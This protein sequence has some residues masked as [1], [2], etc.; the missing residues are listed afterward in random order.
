MGTVGF[1]TTCLAQELSWVR[2]LLAI[3]FTSG[4]IV[5]VLAAAGWL[6]VSTQVRL[7]WLR[8]KAWK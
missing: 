4:A 6:S 2:P 5:G 7:W 8:R 1:D 3:G